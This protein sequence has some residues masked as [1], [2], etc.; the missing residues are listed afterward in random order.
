MM[1]DLPFIPY[2]AQYYRAPTPLPEDWEK[3]RSGNQ[4]LCGKVAAAVNGCISDFFE[5][6]EIDMQEFETII[7]ECKDST[8]KFYYECIRMITCQV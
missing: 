6:Y 4:R 5:G 1:K 7:E 2:G 3:D 8:R